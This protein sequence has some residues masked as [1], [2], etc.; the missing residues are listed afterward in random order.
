MSPKQTQEPGDKVQPDINDLKRSEREAK[1]AR[2]YA[3]A[4]IRTA[5]D[6]LIVLRADLH[7]NTANEALSG[8]TEKPDQTE[9]RLIYDLGDQQWNI[10]KLRILLEDVLPQ[11]F[12]RRLRGHARLSTNRAAHDAAQRPAGWN[13]TTARRKWFS[14]RSKT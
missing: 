7:V 9:G 4:T 5:R 14:S 3:E 11:Q 1:A 2:D 8:H 6:P 12:L 10:P 13:G